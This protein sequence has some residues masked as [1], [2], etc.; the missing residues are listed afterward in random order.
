VETLDVPSDRPSG[1]PAEDE[2]VESLSQQEFLQMLEGNLPDY[3]PY[4]EHRPQRDKERANQFQ[5]QNLM[6]LG[7]KRLEILKGIEAYLRDYDRHDHSTEFHG[8]G[9]SGKT[10]GG[11]FA[12]MVRQCDPEDRNM[13]NGEL[14]DGWCIPERFLRREADGPAS[15]DNELCDF[16]IAV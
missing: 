13:P 5:F 7:W 14:W 4:D 2:Y 10:L 12:D 11:L 6:R 15:N 3:K 9:K 16:D 1:G 8:N